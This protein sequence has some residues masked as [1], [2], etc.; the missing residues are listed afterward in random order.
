M[1]QKYV[2]SEGVFTLR[3]LRS[4]GAAAILEILIFA[5]LAGILIWQEL[6]PAP[7]PPPNA[8]PPMEIPPNPPPPPPPPPK[9]IPTPQPPQ[10]QPLSEVP[11]VPTPIPTPN[12]VPVQPPQPP[13]IPVTSKAPPENIMSEFEASMKAAIDAAKVYP[14]EAIL[15]GE[16]GV[17]TISFDYINGVVS[18]IHVDKSSGARSLDK[19]AMM[20][21]QKAAMPPK[22]AEIAGVNHFVILVSFNLGG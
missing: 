21:V 14:K 5:G 7:P 1:P 2:F 8:Q 19:A 20:A 3:N 22:P 11:P 12:A 17:T 6:H 15:A 4:M 13:P 9:N 18:N 16:A 10:P